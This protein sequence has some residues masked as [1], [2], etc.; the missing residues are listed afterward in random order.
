MVERI[1]IDFVSGRDVGRAATENQLW[2][3]GRCVRGRISVSHNVGDPT[4]RSPSPQPSPSG[5]GRIASRRR[6][7]LG[8]ASL[9]SGPKLSVVTRSPLGRGTVIPSL[10]KVR[11][12]LYPGIATTRSMHSTQRFWRP[13][14]LW[15]FP[16]SPAAAPRNTSADSTPA[17]L[18]RGV[19]CRFGVRNNSPERFSHPPAYHR[20]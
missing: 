18:D 10:I 8:A 15:P 6:L 14:H 9:T 17:I 19:L 5:R 16:V 20:R 3:A 13:R 7:K 2:K 4:V 11:C 12:A 1:K